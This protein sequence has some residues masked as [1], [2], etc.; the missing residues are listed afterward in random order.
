[1]AQRW[2]GIAAVVGSSLVGGLA[3]GSGDGANQSESAGVAGDV[4]RGR[5]LYAARCASCHGADPKGTDRGPSHLSK[6]YEPSHHADFAF[7]AAVADGVRAHHWRFGDMPR[8]EGL[9]DADV[10]AII[11]YVRDE[12]QRRGLQ[13]YPP[14]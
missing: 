9:S 5:G 10:S 8:V 11:A 3:C 13:P 6:V 1:M 12:Q 2:M 7:R 14:P 4:A